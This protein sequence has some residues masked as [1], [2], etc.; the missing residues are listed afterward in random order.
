MSKRLAFPVLIVSPNNNANKEVFQ[1]EEVREG[2]REE[3]IH[4]SSLSFEHWA[5]KTKEHVR[6]FSIYKKRLFFL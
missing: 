2:G 4:S 5:E 1:E 6:D 3:E